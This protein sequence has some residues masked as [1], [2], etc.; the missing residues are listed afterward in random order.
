MALGAGRAVARAARPERGQRRPRRGRAARG[1]RLRAG[2]PRRR[3]ASEPARPQ[4]GDGVRPVARRATGPPA[5]GRRP[6]LALPACRAD[7]RPAPRRRRPAAPPPR[8]RRAPARPGDGRVGR[9]D[10]ARHRGTPPRGGRAGQARRALLPPAARRRVVDRHLPA[11]ALGPRGRRPRAARR[12]PARRR[13]RRRDPAD[14]RRHRGARRARD[15]RPRDDDR[16]RELRA[17]RVRARRR[18]PTPGPLQLDGPRPRAGRARD[19]EPGCPGRPLTP[20]AAGPSPPP[21]SGGGRCHRP[22]TTS[23]TGAACSSSA[24]PR[25]PLARPCSRGS[26]PCAPGPASSSWPSRPPWRSPS[27]WRSPRRPS[28]PRPRPRAAA[29]SPPRAR[30]RPH[31]PRRRAASAPAPPP[32]TADG[33]VEPAAVEALHDL[34]RKADV[35]CAG[36]GLDDGDRS[37]A[38]VAALA[39]ALPQA[40][41]V[42]LDAY[43]LGALPARPEVAA[44]LKGRL[45]LTPNTSE[46]GILLEREA[47]ETDAVAGAALEIAARYGCVV[48]LRSAVANPDGDLWVGGA[49]QPGLGT[50]GSGDVLAGVVA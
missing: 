38:L 31:L 10:L 2:L 20:G 6:R 50:S 29:F 41:S 40:T 22:A 21:C 3:R 45:V 4:A 24:V 33:S 18:R 48:A 44:A 19:E 5:A 35:V 47:P 37:T 25:R 8:G 16:L 26:P 12:P 34:A 9:P 28:P 14:A 13:S 17:H 32:P 30:R 27:P 15:G 1:T 7:R 11:A 39:E 23:T 49:G 43:A 42:V 36:P 46:A